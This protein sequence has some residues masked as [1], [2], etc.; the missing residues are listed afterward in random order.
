M[1]ATEHTE[2]GVELPEPVR[3]AVRFGD[4]VSPPS[5]DRLSH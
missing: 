5:A 1:V 4:R 3:V 2:F